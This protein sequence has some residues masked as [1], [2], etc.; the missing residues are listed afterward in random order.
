MRR[1]ALPPRRTQRLV[2]A[3]RRRVPAFG[4][5]LLCLWIAPGCRPSP[6]LEIVEPRRGTVLNSEEVTV[7]WRLVGTEPA[8]GDHYHVFLDRDLPAAGDPIPMGDPGVVHVVGRTTHTFHDLAPGPHRLTVVLG[9]AAHRARGGLFRA[10]VP[11][12]V[13][14]RGAP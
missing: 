14:P 12:R 2:P 8:A 5:L 9:D 7:V 4:A 13:A 10:S 3:R 1:E 11:F 6:R